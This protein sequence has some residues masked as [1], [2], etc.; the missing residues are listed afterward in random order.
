MKKYCDRPDLVRR[1]EIV[2]EQTS[3]WTLSIVVFL[4]K[5][6]DLVASLYTNLHLRGDLV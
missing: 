6:H 2:P 4:E 3:F 1:L 5:N